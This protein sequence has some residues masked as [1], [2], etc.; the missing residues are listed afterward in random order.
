MG[1][2]EFHFRDPAAGGRDL[3]DALIEAADG[4]DRGGGIFAFASRTGIDKLLTD[5]ELGPVL[6]GGGFEIVVGVDSVTDVAALERLTELTEE[7]H[8]LSAR[9][10]VHDLPGLFHPKICWFAAGDRLR[11]VV[12]SGN[13]TL[14]GLV[15]NTE[16][17]MVNALEGEQAR[18][19][20]TAIRSWLERWDRCLLFP[21]DDRA[22]DSAAENSGSERA[23]RHPMKRVTEEP[24]ADDMP[25]IAAG[26]AILA[27]DVSKN[28]ARGRTQLEVGREMFSSYFGA[29]AGRHRRVLIQSIDASGNPGEVEPSRTL[30]MSRSVN[31]RIELGAGHGRDYPEEG[32]P[33][34]IFARC[35]DG[36]FRYQLIWPEDAGHAGADRLLTA[37]AGRAAGGKMR[38]ELG[39]VAQLREVWPD[40]PLLSA[41][42]ATDDS[43]I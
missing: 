24:G 32:R 18:V 42:E 10:L 6:A 34:V 43:A 11:L 37:L 23:L 19:A 22:R 21:G 12:G 33:I 36:I 8:G 29:E 14:G 16:A 2:A 35:Q 40:S 41:L 9:V 1:V 13:L 26:D 31:F 30:F 3:L 4:A 28:V 5:P 25:P 38:R 7:H 20:E 39:T 15:R 27:L 17:F